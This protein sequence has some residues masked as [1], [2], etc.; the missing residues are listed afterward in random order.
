MVYILICL[1]HESILN[2]SAVKFYFF[3]YI[4]PKFNFLS[5]QYLKF[6]TFYTFQLVE[7]VP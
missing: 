2:I 6:E 5:I 7:N 3:K 4:F 1:G